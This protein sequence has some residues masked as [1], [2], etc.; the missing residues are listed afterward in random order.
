MP[1]LALTA[2]FGER[3]TAIHYKD[4]LI[5]PGPLFGRSRL[6]RYLAAKE[7][8]IR[9][10][11]A[12]HSH[13]EHIGNTAIASQF[14]GAPV[15]GSDITLQ[16]VRDPETR[17]PRP[18]PE[19]PLLLGGEVLRADRL[20]WFAKPVGFQLSVNGTPVG[21]ARLSGGWKDYDFLVPARLLRSGVNSFLF[22][23]SKLPRR[24]DPQY[25]DKN[26]VLA[27]EY[28]EMEPHDQR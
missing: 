6:E 7:G 15:Y 13:E 23:Y 14:T 18:E 17:F 27:V 28:L 8:T 3:F 12:T 1:S 9:A 24:A 4:A 26:A 10:I 25:R 21:R 16:S 20:E 5:D 19:A 11:V 22:T 2:L